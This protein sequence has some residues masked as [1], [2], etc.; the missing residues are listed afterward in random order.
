MEQLT[1][2]CTLL[3][4]RKMTSDSLRTTEVITLTI[5]AAKVDNSMLLNRILPESEINLKKNG[6]FFYEEIDAQHCRFCLLKEYV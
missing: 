1:K 3:S 4:S 5:I 6:E 2:V